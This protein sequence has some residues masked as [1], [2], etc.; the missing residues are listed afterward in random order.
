MESSRLIQDV[1]SKRIPSSGVVT[2]RVKRRSVRQEL[3]TLACL[4]LSRDTKD[5]FL[6][7]PEGVCRKPSSVSVQCIHTNLLKCV[8]DY[9]STGITRN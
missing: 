4:I 3:A 1:L 7:A 5:G 2:L 9:V 8:R 6:S